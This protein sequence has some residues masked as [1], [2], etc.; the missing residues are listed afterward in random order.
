VTPRF[1]AGRPSTARVQS[2][3][4]PGSARRLTIR[5]KLAVAMGVPSLALSLFVSFE[6]AD[7][8]SEIAEVGRQS[9]LATSADGP[10]GLFVALQN[11]RNWAVTELFGQSGIVDVEVAGYP[12]T[13][14]DTDEAL[15]GFEALLTHSPDLTVKAYTPAV[16]R[17]QADL[18]GLR[19]RIDAYD[20]PR[21]IE[22][23]PLANEVFAGYAELIEPFLDGTSAVVDVVEHRDLRRGAAVIDTNLRVIETF[24]SMV[25]GTILYAVMSEGGV[26][27]AE[28]IG[29]LSAW[30]DQFR[31]HLSTLEADSTGVYAP[32][33]DD[34]LFGD[35]S[36]QVTGYVDT[37]I[38]TGRL[39]LGPF[40]ELL[41]V[42]EEHSFIGYQHRVATILREEAER[43]NDAAA[44]RR[45]SYLVIVAGVWIVALAGMSVVGRSI[46]KTLHSLTGQ[47]DDVARRRLPTAVES[48]LDT[49]PGLDIAVPEPEPVAV[50]SRDEV[51]DVA[52][53]LNTVQR[54]ALDLAVGQA[55]L[56]R[57]TSESLVNLGRR[58]QSLLVR[59]LSFITEL[60][61]HE[62]DPDSLA[63]LFHLDHL[64]TRMRRNAE[65][66]L[67]LG[68][69]RARSR[70]RSGTPARIPDVIRSALG[71]VE[72]Y[73]RVV[74]PAVRPV[75]VAGHAVA[76]LVHLLAE[77]L[78][79]ALQ[80][81]PPQSAVE[82]RGQGHHDGYTLTVVDQGMGMHADE[83]T[84]AN[85]RLAG[86][87]RFTVA[88]SKY[89]GHY[90]AG[91]LASRHDIQVRLQG[92][93]LGGITATVHL[94]L[95]ILV[96]EDAL[97]PQ[98]LRAS[99]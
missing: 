56:R 37:A 64:A 22:A 86:G 25:R 79:N 90:V 18:A 74:A 7:Q 72:S 57:N 23:M 71:E 50:G 68:G 43:M 42:P 6:I 61:K 34:Q 45:R 83:I 21:T 10:T 59:Q 98:R 26:D 97:S 28:E 38:S 62:T 54:S 13:R 20:G 66:L 95:D 30:R 58:N 96:A 52:S 75:R 4:R 99:R 8:A 1:N 87:E 70:H 24:A 51:A 48:V 94:P 16:E 40:L 63:N 89:L 36:Q 29:G 14:A 32:A 35:W 80:Y 92:A 2:K 81:S 55:V 73:R 9:E 19:D 78:D 33:V 53:A 27:T 93:P 82:I 5:W 46:V 67:V 91:H 77:L 41:T 65:S 49:P 17:V 39:D 11:E 84:R 47:A 76:D 3:V 60:E 15:A 88:P 12:A 85:E 69:V 44:A 31:R